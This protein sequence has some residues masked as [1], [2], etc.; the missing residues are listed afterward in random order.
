ML[1]FMK[2]NWF[3]V[4]PIVVYVVFWSAVAFRR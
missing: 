4:L 2:D 3:F 1:R